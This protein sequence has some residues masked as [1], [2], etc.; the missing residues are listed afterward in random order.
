MDTDDLY[1]ALSARVTAD[2]IG[3]ETDEWPAYFTRL[4]DLIRRV[5]AESTE[6]GL[7][8][9]EKD[10]LIQRLLDHVAALEEWW[11]KLKPKTK[12]R[13]DDLVI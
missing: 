5:V 4:R 12:K 11:P 8:T 10:S 1:K 3:R 7:S 9:E 2:A 6:G 13:V